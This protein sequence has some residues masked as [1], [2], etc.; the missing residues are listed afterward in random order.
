[1]KRFENLSLKNKIFF[2]T[3]AF[4]LLLSLVIALFTRW[5]LI[6]SLTSELELRGLGIAR[7]IANNSREFILTENS[8]ELTDLIFEARRSG[9]IDLV[10]YA[11][12]MD[13]EGGLLCHTFTE[14]FP[15]SLLLHGRARP[16]A[17]ESMKLLRVLGNAV[18]DVAVPVNEGIYEIGRVH[19]GLNKRHIDGLFGKL[20]ITFLGF[21][22]AVTVFFFV[23]SNMLSNYI[24]RPITKLIRLSDEISRGNYDI[25]PDFETELVCPAEKECGR[26]CENALDD[27]GDEEG[28]NNGGHVCERRGTPP[29]PETCH[30]CEYCRD[31]IK[32]EVR[33]LSNSFMNMTRR[34]RRSRLKMRESEEKY[35]SL[36][37]SGPNPIFVCDFTT[38]EILAANPAAEDTFGHLRTE[39]IGIPFTTLGPF[40]YGIPYPARKEEEETAS[41]RLVRSKVQ[42]YRKD[43]SPIHVNVFASPGRFQERRALIVAT[44]DISEIV[45]KDSQLIQASKMTN[46][47]KMSAGIAHE[48]NQPLN[49][50]K[51][52]SEYLKV[53]IEGGKA[54]PDRDLFHV[55]NEVSS[56][57]D[58]ASDIIKR[59]RDF[60]RK[61][62]FS[63]EKV[64]L[65]DPV[66]SVAQI[67]GKQLSLQNIELTLDL[68]EN[69]P[70][71]LA[72]NNRLEQ[73]L[74]NLVTNA[75]D[76]ITQ[77][78]EED[79]TYEGE[80]IEIQSK[81]AGSQVEVTVS[82][83]GCGIPAPIRE[84]I[85]EAFFTTKEMGE[86]MGMGLSIIYGI[87][88]DYQGDI[89]VEST[90]GEGTT[91]RV[92][93]PAAD[94]EPG[95]QA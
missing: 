12:I 19:V 53:M 50:I 34:I 20:R 4:I 1:M 6:S 70:Y 3:L 45:E 77:R 30:Q 82:D 88:R 83:T 89:T 51:M 86:G 21:L 5:V 18:F 76:A 32:D 85:F 22:S 69:I 91:F 11:F 37:T 29:T 39:L 26:P 44:T 56:Q 8:A 74:F 27:D 16:D 72:H 10:S 78:R 41:A 36:F 92:T 94:V 62:D 63:R 60:G 65:N 17:I 90:V 95:Y 42:Y 47:G 13:K 71:I 9:R 58:R 54:I 52:G 25:E 68:T 79:P 28:E 33:Q 49:A 61:A 40:E 57:V 15:E 7:S 87:I 38:L 48:L 66:R 23:I 24:T 46:L 93:F 35:R 2:S 55:V 14:E 43:G 81:V 64:Y 84:R 31:S 75:R 59:L 67:V 80:V 73:V